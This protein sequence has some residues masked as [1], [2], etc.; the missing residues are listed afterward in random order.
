MV[1]PKNMTH[2]N[3]LAIIQPVLRSSDAILSLKGFLKSTT[4]TMM[5]LWFLHFISTDFILFTLAHFLLAASASVLKTGSDASPKYVSAGSFWL[6][7]DV[8]VC[9]C[10]PVDDVY[11][12]SSPLCCLSNHA[13]L[14]VA[15]FLHKSPF[16]PYQRGF[17]CN[18]DSISLPYKGS[19]V[20]NTVL[21]AV[22]VTLP[23][24]SVSPGVVQ[25]ENE[26][27]CT[28]SLSIQQIVG[29]SHLKTH[30]WLDSDSHSVGLNVS[31]H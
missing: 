16:P 8:Y 13:V 29:L 20:S 24:V 27:A 12:C 9:V 7:V 30:H 23:V 26:W 4:M 2:R 15:G 10:L 17:F 22:G 6:F 21:T 14:L 5:Y 1:S 28:G 19:T 11:W 3:L 18:D 25:R 31:P